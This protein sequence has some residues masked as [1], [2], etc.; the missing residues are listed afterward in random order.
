MTKKT[1]K[2]TITAATAKGKKITCTITVKKAPKKVTLNKKKVT[3]TKGKT[4]KIKVKLPKNTASYKKTYKSSNKKVAT[5]SKSGT[6]K[7]VKKGKAVITVK[8]FNKKTAKIQIT[9]K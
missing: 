7:A 6:I 5:V 8:T 1:G 3:L 2:A 4:F 9:V